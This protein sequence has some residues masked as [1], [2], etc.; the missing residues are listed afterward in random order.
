MQLPIVLD[1][2]LQGGGPRGR[3]TP[4]YFMDRDEKAEYEAMF[5]HEVR[6]TCVA[7]PHCP[8]RGP[9]HVVHEVFE[10]SLSKNNK[11]SATVIEPDLRRP[12]IGR[13]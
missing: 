4:F 12:K 5:A 2:K 3:P 9:V 10:R 7:H 13:R 1:V 11:V 8:V 6:C